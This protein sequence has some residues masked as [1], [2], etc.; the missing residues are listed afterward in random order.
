MIGTEGVGVVVTFVAVKEVCS[1]MFSPASA[2]MIVPILISLI[3]IV[4]SL[5]GIGGIMGAEGTLPGLTLLITFE[6]ASISFWNEA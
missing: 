2:L 1:L 3:L 5:N 6:N 4:F